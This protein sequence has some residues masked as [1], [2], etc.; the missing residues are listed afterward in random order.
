MAYNEME[1]SRLHTHLEPSFASACVN[2]LYVS[3]SSGRSNQKVARNTTSAYTSYKFARAKATRRYRVVLDDFTAKLW[4]YFSSMYTPQGK[5]SFQD[6]ALHTLHTPYLPG[7][8]K[9]QECFPTP[10]QSLNPSERH[11]PWLASTWSAVMCKDPTSLLQ[12]RATS[13][14]RSDFHMRIRPESDNTS[15]KLVPAS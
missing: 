14:F 3:V 1:S 12:M 6:L 11:L 8:P 13:H 2:A 5:E 4:S 10:S 15:I 9:H 7:T